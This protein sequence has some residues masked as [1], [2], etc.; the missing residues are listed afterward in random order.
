MTRALG[1]MRV[2]LRRFIG[3]LLLLVG[4]TFLI[5]MTVRSAPGDAIDAITPMGTPDEV[6]AKL[7]AEFGLDRDP[8]SGYFMWLANS[9]GG[10]FGE[11]LVV[12]PGEPV[13]SVA[14]GAFG[15]TLILAVVSLLVCLTLALLGAIAFKRV[16]RVGQ[17][18]SGILY[19]LTSAPS[20]VVAVCMM[21]LINWGVFT[22]LEQ[23]GYVVPEWYPIPIYTDSYMPFVFAIIAL[24]L[25]DG[26]FMEYFNST[27]SELDGVRKAQFVAAVRSKGASTTPHIVRNMLVPVAAGYA[28]RLPVVLGGAVIVEYVFTLEGAGYL[29]LEAAKVRDFPVVVGLSVLFTAVIIGVTVL[30]DM[31]RSAIDPREVSHGG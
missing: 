10:D 21:L 26:L 14:M 23:T 20:F 25:G 7:M 27:R 31:V 2:S 5:Y 15:Q 17:L 13:M 4:A 19:V 24:V 30:S 1:F 22:Y 8:V 28:A 29:L 9:T 6:K 18:G 3:G 16:G 11:S 12:S